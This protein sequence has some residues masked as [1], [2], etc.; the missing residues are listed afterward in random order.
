M[1]REVTREKEEGTIGGGADG[2][3]WERVVCLEPDRRKDVAARGRWRLGL[4]EAR[5]SIPVWYHE[6]RLTQRK[7]IPLGLMRQINRVHGGHED[8]EIE[9]ESTGRDS[10]KLNTE[11][12]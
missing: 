7:M 9:T 5:G 2:R 1:R 4:A 10:R 11:T 6:S 3:G 12:I 8:L